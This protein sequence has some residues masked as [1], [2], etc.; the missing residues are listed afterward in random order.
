[1][2]MLFCKYLDMYV[3][4]LGAYKVESKACKA[5]SFNE[6]VLKEASFYIRGEIFFR[7]S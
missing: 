3:Q 6:V 1:M 5:L 2:L 4:D 7:N